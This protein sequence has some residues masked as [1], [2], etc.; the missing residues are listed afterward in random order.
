M[1]RLVSIIFLIITS[2]VTAAEGESTLFHDL[3]IVDWV[4]RCAN[5]KIPVTYNNLLEGGYFNMPSAL[6]GDEGEIG[7]GLSYVPPYHMYSLRFQFTDRIELSG[8]YRVFRGIDDPILSP[9]GFGDK[10]DKGINV[11]F[12]LL[13]EKDTQNTLPSIAFGLEDFVGTK[14]FKSNYVVATK[15]FLKFN[16]EASIGYGNRRIRGWFGGISWFPFLRIG[17]RYT[18]DLAFVAEYDAIPYKSKRWEPHPDGHKSRSQINYGVK[19]RLFDS[20]D[21]SSSYIRG[22]KFAFSISTF[23]NFGYTEGL[24]CKRD[25]PLPCK[26]SPSGPLELD[27]ALVTNLCP[28]LENQGFQLVEA[29]LSENCFN[30]K[31]LRLTITNNCYRYECDVRRRLNDLLA[32]LIPT[33][34]A[35]V[36]VTIK[37]MGLPIQEYHY[38]MA[39][40]RLYGN[41]KVGPYELRVLSPLCDVE[42]ENTECDQLLFYQKQRLWNVD[43]YPRYASFFGS[44][45]GKFKYA[46]GVNLGLNGYLWKNVNYFILLGYNVFSNLYDLKDMDRLNP[47]QLINVRTDIVNYLKR[48]GLHVDEAYLQKNWNLGKGWFSRVSFGYFEVEYGGIASEALWY[49]ANSHY[50]FGIEAAVVRKRCYTGLGFSDSVRKLH[51]FHPSYQRFLGTQGF[52]SA[53]YH[54]DPMDMDFELKAGKFLANDLG[55]RAEIS[56]TYPSGTRVYVWGTFTNGNDK[57]NGRRYYDKGIAISIPLDILYTY[58]SKSRWIYSMS[59]WLRDVGVSA[60]TGKTLYRLIQDERNQ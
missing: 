1:K 55:V 24:Q 46:L 26:A 14:S 32:A 12:A 59:A 8:N 48:D 18:R 36:V 5:E 22:E 45:T 6:M 2:T 49:P 40:V 15:S 41:D 52:V 38:L 9:H 25:N 23:Y 57:I 27:D 47:S 42:F 16:A 11:K 20:F 17:N 43:L 4:N 13:T 50:A 29:W 34:I 10:S 39:Y 58:T 30:E 3:M 37:T 21:F 60:Y 44:S 28:P 19:Y 54:A 31:T 35:Y 7:V 56:R 53:Y 51:G 33:D